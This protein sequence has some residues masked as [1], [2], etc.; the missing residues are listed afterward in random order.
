MTNDVETPST[1]LF[2]LWHFYLIVF[3][4]TWLFW[5]SAAV[6]GTGIQSSA[7]EVLLLLGLL[8]PALGGVGYTLSQ[9]RDGRREYWLRVVSP[10]RIPAVW[11][12]IIVI[13]APALMTLA[14][15]LDGAPGER[16]T[17]ARI[18]ERVTPLLITPAAFASS[19]LRVL[20][21]GPV[22]EELGWRGYALDRLQAH[23][24]ALVSSLIQ[25]SIWALWHLPLFF[26]EGTYHHSRG[27]GSLWFWLFVAQAV[28]VTV[29]FT[30]IYNN[31]RRSTLAAILFHFMINVTY[32]LVRPTDRANLFAT[33]LW[34]IAAVAVVAA[35]NPR[36][37]NRTKPAKPPSDTGC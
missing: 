14:V 16:S 3:A 36:K 2:S 37:S 4:W 31:T 7:G 6:T 34:F 10:T 23:W 15:L 5:I 30:W 19:L 11:Y 33:I 27:V 1:T 32:E 13:F 35:W 22:P 12:L 8:G 25:G 17:L 24:N 29:L 21:Y 18:E 20:F 28:P 26:I 9:N